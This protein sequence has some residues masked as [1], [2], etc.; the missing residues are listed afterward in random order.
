MV[1]HKTQRKSL[2]ITP[3]RRIDFVDITD[4]LTRNT[5]QRFYLF[6]EKR[7]LVKSHHCTRVVVREIDN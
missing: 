7:G 3:R 4:R 6:I 5:V 1:V 2:I